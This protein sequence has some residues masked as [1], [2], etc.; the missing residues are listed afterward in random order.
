MRIRT[1]ARS[2]RATWH[3]SVPTTTQWKVFLHHN[4]HEHGEP[5][6]VANEAAALISPI[7]SLTET[8]FFRIQ[9]T[10][11]DDLG[12]K[13]IREARLYPNAA[14][15]A[16]QAAWSLALQPLSAGATPQILDAAATLSDADSPGFEFGKL[17]VALSAAQAGDTLTILPEGSAPG[18][19]GLVAG[20]LTFGGVL[21]AGMSEGT[22]AAPLEVRF[23]AAATPAAAQAILRR[24][25]GKFAT[26][27]N[28]GATATIDDGDGGIRTTAPLVLRVGPPPNQPPVVSIARPV[29]GSA[30]GA[31]ALIPIVANASDAD[32]RIVRVEFFSGAERLAVATAPPFSF[33]WSGVPPG[34]YSV[35]ARATDNVGAFTISAPVNVTVAGPDPLPAPWQAQNIGNTLGLA[36]NAGGIFTLRASGAGLGIAADELHFMW[37]PWSGDGEIVAHVESIRKIVVQSF[38]GLTFRESLLPGARHVSM[39]LHANTRAILRWR[40]GIV[41][42][43]QR[44]LAPE[45]D[46]PGWLKLSRRGNVFTGSISTDGAAW[47]V[48][49]T[50]TVALPERCLVGLAG[51]SVRPGSLTLVVFSNVTG[52]R[53]LGP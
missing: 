35:T 18:Q 7:H 52:P 21:V 5:A 4:E 19:V 11:T 38:G 42:T 53:P 43:V 3:V 14:N 37:Q 17:R 32:G 46:L 45:P 27:G 10:V 25:A 20:K 12:A 39:N 22:D 1:S 51:A 24:V 36:S 9:L 6:V 31:P 23:N 48:V 15:I 2:W 13:V 26:V 47:T 28:R 8:Y 50:A 44:I 29:I 34:S 33:A 49:G 40:D 16:P 41:P 30:Y